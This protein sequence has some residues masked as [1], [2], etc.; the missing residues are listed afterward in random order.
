MPSD[1]D[2]YKEFLRGPLDQA[3]DIHLAATV[4]QRPAT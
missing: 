2:P 3:G 1:L 4:L